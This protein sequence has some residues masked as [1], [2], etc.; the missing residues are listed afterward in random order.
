MSILNVPELPLM[1][2]GLLNNFPTRTCMQDEAIVVGICVKSVWFL[3]FQP[4]KLKEK[5]AV[6]LLYLYDVMDHCFIWP[7]SQGKAYSS[8]KLYLPTFLPLKHNSWNCDAYN[9]L[10]EPLWVIFTLVLHITCCIKILWC[11]T[12][13][14][15]MNSQC[16]HSDD[17]FSLR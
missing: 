3:I 12:I 7:Y 16:N 15:T 17:A 6:S 8:Q 2:T 14:H 9:C 13:S 4:I 1:I 11:P 10:A 5:N